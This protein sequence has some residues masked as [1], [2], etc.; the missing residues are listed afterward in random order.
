MEHRKS[1]FWP[2]SLSTL[3]VIPQHSTLP[4]TSSPRDPKFK[5]KWRLILRREYWLPRGMRLSSSS[6]D[7]SPFLTPMR[8]RS[9]I[10]RS[11]DKTSWRQSLRRR[12]KWSSLIP[13]SSSL[14]WLSMLP[15]RQLTERVT[16]PSL[17][18]EPLKLLSQKCWRNKLK[19]IRR[20]WPIWVSTRT[21][22]LSTCVITW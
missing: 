9:R 1:P 8:M 15:S 13:V 7:L 17:K 20:W 18:P 14:I 6:W 5:N 10:P 21:K 16:R 22:S 11:K 19:P 4:T 12:E 3:L 2:E